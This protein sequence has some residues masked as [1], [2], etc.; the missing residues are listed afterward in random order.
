MARLYALDPAQRGQLQQ[1]GH[2]LAG[3]LDVSS[4]LAAMAKFQALDPQVKAQ[5]IAAFL[6][7]AVRSYRPLP[8]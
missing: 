4:P 1:S 5:L 3:L 2:P 8:S 7:W 6:R